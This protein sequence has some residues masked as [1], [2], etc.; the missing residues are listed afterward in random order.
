[1]NTIALAQRLARNLNIDDPSNPDAD[2]LLDILS[3]INGG[4]NEFYRLAPAIYRRT[5]LSQTLR[6]PLDVNLTFH[7]KYSPIVTGTPFQDN[8]LGCTVRLDGY[9]MDN[10]VNGPS[11][12]LDD[13][14]GDTLTMSGKVYF[15]AF[16]IF[17]QIETVTS[18]VRI[19]S[20]ASPH[21]S[22]MVRDS[23]SPVRHPHRRHELSGFSGVST[24][25]IGRPVNYRIEPIASSQGIGAA[26]LIRVHPMPD[27]DYIV[28]FEAQIINPRVTFPQMK[29]AAELPI[30]PQFCEDILVPL[31]EGQLSSSPFWN[32]SK[33]QAASR[34]AAA[35]ER[36]GL[37]PK[38]L[39][40]PN[41][42]V[43]TRRGW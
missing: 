17:A 7:A 21:Q 20:L 6:A 10:T 16:P 13:F 4:L 30:L 28:R 11:V 38:D 42:R 3:A 36:I 12:L 23:S 8:W 41:N 25:L 33:P 43:G 24:K 5:T 40:V 22:V 27:V 32:G 1:M 29:V 26:C 18:D 35:V 39:A 19:S 31:C 9:S 37:L 2:A 14:L 15:D 34:A